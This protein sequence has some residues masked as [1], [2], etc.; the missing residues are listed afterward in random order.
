M[1]SKYN[2]EELRDNI[3]KVDNSLMEL[4]HKR[5]EMVKKVALYKMENGIAIL[6]EKREE[7]VIKKNLSLLKVPEIEEYAQEFLEQLMR[8]SREFQLSLI[9]DEKEKY[10]KSEPKTLTLGFYGVKGSNTDL[11]MREYFG[12][13]QKSLSCREF[14]DVFIALK[15]NQINYGVVP[16]ENS[17]TGAIVDVY[18]LLNEYDFYITGEICI[19][20]N[21]N[22][23][24]VT[25]ASLDTIEEVYSHPQV[26]LQSKDFLRTHPNWKLIPYHDTAKSAEFVHH[27]NNI[28]MAVIAGKRFS[29]IYGLNILKAN[30]NT[31][32][33]NTTRF[34]IIGKLPLVSEECNKV[35]VIFATQHKAGCLFNVLRHF[36]E[37]S[38]NLLKIE[39]RPMKNKTWEY[40]FHVDFE[41]NLKEEKV[42]VALKLIKENSHY[43]KILGNYVKH[44]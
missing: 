22:L 44:S 6:N 13:K 38:I 2:L 7:E 30:I 32:K 17:S 23:M 9:K 19:K 26:F 21:N 20:I 18:D 35:S 10:I 25:G 8:V 43:F 4:F 29:E 28:K 14:E 42:E 11:A 34:A 27:S 40:F 12:D 33:S 16:I 1:D 15:N 3:D 5:M 41:G 24:A 31:A 37:N 36:A 39:S